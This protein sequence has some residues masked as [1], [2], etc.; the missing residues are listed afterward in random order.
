VNTGIVIVA[1]AAVAVGIAIAVSSKKKG[2]KVPSG[3]DEPDDVNDNLDKPDDPG[4][5]PATGKRAALDKLTRAADL[6]EDW[7]Q[8]FRVVARGESGFNNLVGLGDPSLFPPWAKPNLTASAAAKANEAK[9]AR[10]AYDRNAAKRYSKCPYPKSRY[11]FGSGGWFG[12]LPGNMLAAFW[13]TPLECAD[14]WLVFEQEAGL[15]FAIAMAKRILGNPAYQKRPAFKWIRVAWASV[16]LIGNEEFLA[17]KINKWR[18]HAQDAG[19]SPSL[20]DQKPSHLPKFNYPQLYHAL[21]EA[22]DHPPSA[23]GV[24]IWSEGAL[25]VGLNSAGTWGVFG[26][27]ADK[28]AIELWLRAEAGPPPQLL[29]S[30]IGGRAAA[31]AWI[32]ATQGGPNA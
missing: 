14:P 31:L 27:D 23:L 22:G 19:V 3:P 5:Q 7:R 8:F 10:I 1:A 2:P 6:P 28:R 18:G 24:E 17:K 15:V 4:P 25:L 30:G 9:A 29:A 26:G 20:L 16:S 12:G 13:N 32:E 21:K 11:V